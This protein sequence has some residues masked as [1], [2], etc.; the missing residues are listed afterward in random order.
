MP[1]GLLW[2]PFNLDCRLGVF[3]FIPLLP[4]IPLEFIPLPLEFIP[5]LPIA[6]E[7][8]VPLEALPAPPVLP[9]WA[10]T[11]VD[12]PIIEATVTAIIPGRFIVHSRRRG[13]RPS[14]SFNRSTKEC[15]ASYPIGFAVIKPLGAMDT[16]PFSRY[17]PLRWST[18]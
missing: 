10:Q 4:S 5:L 2:F 9:L 17:F 16:Q 1:P 7:L 6:L 8:P 13:K 18:A 14:G 15:V 11:A 3:D 12:N